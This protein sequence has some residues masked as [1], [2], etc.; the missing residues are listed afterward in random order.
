MLRGQTGC[1]VKHPCHLS[2]VGDPMR[3]DTLPAP[4]PWRQA[5]V[6]ALTRLWDADPSLKYPRSF[7][8]RKDGCCSYQDDFL[9]E[10][11][12]SEVGGM[13]MVWAGLLLSAPGSV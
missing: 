10:R 9:L 3:P 2:S 1:T 6:G 13:R 5:A 7:S 11:G 12:C 8:R 4:S